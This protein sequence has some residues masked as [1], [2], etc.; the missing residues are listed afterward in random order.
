MS[1][2][3]VFGGKNLKSSSMCYLCILGYDCPKQ[4][5]QHNSSCSSTHYQC[6]HYH[7]HHHHHHHCLEVD[8]AVAIVLQL[9]VDRHVTNRSLTLGSCRV[10]FLTSLERKSSSSPSW[11]SSRSSTPMLAVWWCTEHTQC[12]G[13]SRFVRGSNITFPDQNTLL[14]GIISTLPWSSS[15]WPPSPS[16]ILNRRG[17][18]RSTAATFNPPSKKPC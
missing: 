15:S 3:L 18:V 1:S 6:D 10:F 9:G 16:S 7:H 5:R 8:A 14:K 2:L 4:Y 11:S 13:S 17:H 12:R